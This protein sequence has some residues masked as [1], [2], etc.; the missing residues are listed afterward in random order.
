MLYISENR[1]CL[2]SKNYSVKCPVFTHSHT[3]IV[4]HGVNEKLHFRSIS[5]FRLILLLE[6]FSLNICIFDENFLCEFPKFDLDYGEMNKW[7]INWWVKFYVPDDRTWNTVILWSWE[8]EVQRNEA[9]MNLE[10][11][12][13]WESESEKKRDWLNQ[14]SKL[15]FWFLIGAVTE[16]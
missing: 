8:K 10:K 7:N 3:H 4:S 1:V 2:N 9:W 11:G 13:N 14:K 6:K 5:F 15:Y 16:H 12:R